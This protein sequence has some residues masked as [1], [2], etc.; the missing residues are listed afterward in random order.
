VND[1]LGR[2]LLETGQP[3]RGIALLNA[4]VALEPDRNLV[5]G[6]LLRARALM[7]DWS[8]LETAL[9]KPPP[10]EHANVRYMALA[11][12]AMWRRDPAVAE[13]LE[14]QVEARSFPLREEVLVMLGM[15][16]T[17]K[18]RREMLAKLME[19]GRV[20][21]SGKRRPIFFRQLAAEGLAF[22]GDYDDAVAAVREADSLGLVDLTWLDR[23]PLFETM[24][25]AAGFIAIRERVAAR[26][27]EALDVLEGRID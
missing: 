27:K 7:G 13:A 14:R 6:E 24:R 18:P 26:A 23:C 1:I 15:V 3:Q 10:D 16:R 25:S 11:R 5:V 19:W 4:V 2:L 17:G 21:G 12:L 20:V 8:G 9:E 22:L